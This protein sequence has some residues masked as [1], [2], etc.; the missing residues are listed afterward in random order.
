MPDSGPS[1]CSVL[2]PHAWF[3]P[4][5]LHPEG[6][7]SWGTEGRNTFRWRVANRAAWPPGQ[8]SASRPAALHCDPLPS[9]STRS[10]RTGSVLTPLQ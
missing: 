8:R 1:L 10:D 4:Q 6:E 2:N 9:A 3:D 7:W 5:R